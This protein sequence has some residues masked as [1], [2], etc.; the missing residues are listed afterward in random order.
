M[1][2]NKINFLFFF[3]FK[4]VIVFCFLVFIFGFFNPIKAETK[5]FSVSTIKVIEINHFSEKAQVEDVQTGKKYI[6]N[7]I[8][9][10]IYDDIHK[11]DLWE[12][13]SINGI[14]IKARL[15]ESSGYIVK[16]E[17]PM[18]QWAIEQLGLRYTL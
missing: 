3:C 14:I 1:D 13:L 18:L 12:T 16:W 2:S 9:L 10:D 7:M 11:D 8:S 4:F 6:L 15:L 17:K 5:D